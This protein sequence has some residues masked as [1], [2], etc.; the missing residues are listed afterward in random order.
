[1]RDVRLNGDKRNA[2]FCNSAFVWYLNP[3]GAPEDEVA[4]VTGFNATG[5][6][7]EWERPISMPFLFFLSYHSKIIIVRETARLLL[8]GMPTTALRILNIGFGMG[9]VRIKLC[10]FFLPL[11]T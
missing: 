9:M 2:D 4:L 6:M 8:D 1:M 11:Y 7:M 5:V 10:H 3:R